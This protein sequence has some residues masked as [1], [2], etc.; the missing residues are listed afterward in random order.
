MSKDLKIEAYDD[1]KQ[2]DFYSRILYSGIVEWLKF[3][4]LDKT[5]ETDEEKKSKLYLRLKGTEILNAMLDIFPE[6]FD[7][8][9]RDSDLTNKHPIN[10]IRE[11][12]IAAGEFVEMFDG[13]SI[14]NCE[15]PSINPLYIR[16]LGIGKSSD[17]KNVGI[18]KIKKGSL[19]IDDSRPISYHSGEEIFSTIFKKIKWERYEDILSIEVFNP[20]IKRPPYQCWKNTEFMTEKEIYLARIKI[21]D[22]MFD[23]FWTKCLDEKIYIS[24]INEHLVEFDEI[25]RFILWQRK[26]N[27]NAIDANFEIKGKV[28]FV[29]MFAKMPRR[30]QVV[31]D[32][33]G[34]PINNIQNTK[35]YVVPIEV[36]KEIK[37]LLVNLNFNVKEV[38]YGTV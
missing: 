34:W 27:E 5:N 13:I 33:Y 6:C 16:M 12:M 37:Q 23:Y 14:P 1:E 17:A 21:T 7:Y 30:E 3:S 2:I 10:V 36:W 25:R 18:T 9:Y 11:K 19:T 15:V 32:T 22:Y 4:I 26:Q 20:K 31:F 38:N 24:K 29:Y 8:F 28:V 35:A